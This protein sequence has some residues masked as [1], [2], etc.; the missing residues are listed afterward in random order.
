MSKS[1]DT[2]NLFERELV[3]HF[4]HKTIKTVNWPIRSDVQCSISTMLHGDRKN[5]FN[6]ANKFSSK[7]LRDSSRLCANCTS[8]TTTMSMSLNFPSPDRLDIYIFPR[9]CLNM[10]VVGIFETFSRKISIENV[11][12]GTYEKFPKEIKG[13]KI[14]F[15]IFIVFKFQTKVLCF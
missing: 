14:N 11:F 15:K 13:W 9:M 4:Q 8:T 5:L 7:I 3:C 1:D 10:W 6:V 12:H 2:K